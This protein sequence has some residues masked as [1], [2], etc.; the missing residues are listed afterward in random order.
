MAILT[1][2]GRLGKDCETREL[3]SGT[4]VVSFS[5]ADDVGYGDKK[6]TQW[7]KCAWFGDR[8]TK[9]AQYLTKGSLIEVTGSASADAWVK[10]GE[11]EPRAQLTV[12]VMDVR[13][14]GGGKKS[15]DTP[16]ADNSRATRRDDIDDD[17]P[18]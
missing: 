10:K 6:R 15:D 7:I 14:H 1:V 11:S 3:Q 18:F 9:V 2:T 17:I 5:I 16:V 12:N 8:A 4:K 13:L